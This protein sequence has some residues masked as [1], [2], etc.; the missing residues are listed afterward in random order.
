LPVVNESVIKNAITAG[1]AFNCNIR[2]VTK[3]DR[4][5]Y[6]YPDLPKGYQI[7][8]YDKPI[9]ENG[10][11]EI[12]T[13]GKIEKIRINRI[14]IE[15]DAGKLIHMEGNN[16]Y[17]DYNRCG[18]PLLEIV[19]EPDIKSPEEAVLYLTN[20]KEIFQYLEI[21]DC[22][23]EEGSLRCDANISMM[24]ED[25]GKWIN[26]PIVEVKNMNSFKNVKKA[27]EYEAIRLVEEYK[28]SKITNNGRNKET[29]GWDDSKE[30][31]I[32]QRTKEGESDYRYFPEPDLP[33]LEI[34][35]D[36]VEDRRKNLPELPKPKK[37]RFVREYEITEYDSAALVSQKDIGV[38]FEDISKLTRYYK[39]AA[40]FILTDI[41]AILNKKS[42]T[43]KEFDVPKE[44]IAEIINLL[45][46]EKISSWIGKQLFEKTLVSKKSPLEIMREE[47]LAQI[48]DSNLINIVETVLKD[49]PKSIEDYNNGKD[50]ALKF[51]MGQVMKMSKGKANPVK[52]TE[53]IL[54]SIKK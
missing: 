33:Y 47:N 6:F 27:L 1:I 14:H 50:N 4:K 45:G 5:N 25:N 34:S 37:E 42:I 29:R 28:K 26:T 36:L 53:M 41:A 23:M 46:E 21:S 35:E 54:N 11:I 38:Y 19:S 12:D 31:T 10:Y 44:H 43:I 3:F 16:T 9:C 30:I 32:F 52:A 40:N 39:K 48:D 18:T 49:N 17:I 8:Q 24:I 2:K 51:L 20:L 13:D 7:S 15:E 22:N